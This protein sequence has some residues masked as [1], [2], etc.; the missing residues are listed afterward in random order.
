MRKNQN[1]SEIGKEALK[2]QIFQRIVLFLLFAALAGV[3][4]YFISQRLQEASEKRSLLRY[5]EEG[6]WELAYQKSLEGLEI[7][8][9]DTFFLMMNGFA[10]YQTALAQVSLSD[11]MEYIDICIISLRR[12]LLDR[13]TDK[14]GRIRYVLGKAYYVKGPEY[15]DLSIKYLEEAKAL[16]FSAGDLNEYLGLAYAALQDYR[17]SIEAFSASLDPTQN[18][19]ESALLLL[20]IAQSYIGLEDWENARTYLMRCAAVSRDI[21]L[22][23]R[24]RL[25]LG[26]T[27]VNSGNPDGAVE[28]F[29]SVLE[30]G[31]ENAEALYELGEIY[32]ARDETTRA[33]A[34]WR[35]ARAA[36]PNF[37]PV[38]ARLNIM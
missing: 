20:Y 11:A 22:T 27:L 37:A 9:M 24:S 28:I 4:I 5:W 36:N 12:V 23:I 30:I 2:K 26:K 29:E 13:N 19:E 14:D 21:D 1:R 7:K 32:F 16:S 31:G 15:A 38:L 6:S 33:R 34:L 35:R 25:L 10:A 18:T 8:P 17:S 3:F